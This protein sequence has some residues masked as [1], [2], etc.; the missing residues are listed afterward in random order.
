[1]INGKRVLGIIPARGGSKGL[2]RKN[3]LE[4]C[5][6][7]LISWTIAQASRSKYTDRVFVSTD[8]REI[9][10]VAEKSGVAVPFLRPDEF[11][12]DSSPTWEA[13]IHSLDA[14]EAR[15]E[16]Y[17]Y[18]AILEPT[19]PLRKVGDI[20]SGIARL[21]SSDKAQTLI[22]VGEVH[23]EHPMIVKKVDQAGFVSPYFTGGKS[24]YQRQQVDRAFFPYGVIYL[25]TLASYRLLKTVYS[26]YTLSIEIERWQNYEIDDE[27]DFMVVEQIMKKFIGEING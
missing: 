11:A 18:V 22:S 26:E 13:V 16:R 24:I 8:S 19:S 23:T 6:K 21:A 7:P 20:D 14:F 25:A 10:D 9:A 2:P 1:M 4:I 27:I 17:D 15:G 3:L 5:G 12:R